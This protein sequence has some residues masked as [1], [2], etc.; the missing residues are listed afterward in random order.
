RRLFAGDYLLRLLLKQNRLTEA[1]RLI[2]ELSTPSSP[3]EFNG[4]QAGSRSLSDLLLT[5]ATIL[6][7]LGRWHEA[8]DQSAKGV[9]WNPSNAPACHILIPVLI[10]LNDTGRYCSV[11]GQALR[12]FRDTDDPLTAQ[13]IATDCLMLRVAG[14]DT[15]AAAQ[16]AERATVKR[17]KH[18]D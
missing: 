18:S 2:E 4:G 1:G 16:L 8:A 9:E 17:T 14:L 7:R 5:R 6:A 12:Q 13:W 3:R 10:A 11:C 15:S